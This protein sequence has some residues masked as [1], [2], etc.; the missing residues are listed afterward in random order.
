MSRRSLPSF[1]DIPP[2]SKTIKPGNDFYQYVNENWLDHVHMPSFLSSY[3]VSEEIESKINVN[4]LNILKDAQEE[5]NNKPN[6]ELSISIKLL[7][8]FTQSALH[9]P[10]QK[11]S[12]KFVRSMISSFKCIR[13]VEDVA[14]TLGDFIR[15]RITSLFTVFT[16]PM[17][18]ESTTLR[19]CLTPGSLGLPDTSYYL[20]NSPQQMRTLTAYTK[21]LKK[22][23]EEFDIPRLEIL[24]SL[25]TIAAKQLKISKLDDEI[26]TT[27]ADLSNKYKFIPWECL[28]KNAFAWSP[29]EWKTAKILVISSHWIKSM[30]NWFKTF[31]LDQWKIWLSGSFLLYILPAL[32]PPFDDWHF[33]FFHKRLRDQ[34]EKTPQHRLTLKL[35][36]Q[37]LSAPLGEEFVKNYM[38]KSTKNDAI[39][40][41]E[42]IR[43]VA[44][45]RILETDWL[46]P[47]TRQLAHDKIK[48]IYFGIAYPESFEKMKNITLLPDNLCWNILSLGEYYLENDLKMAN[49]KLKREEWDDPIFLVNAFY[50]NEGNRLIIPSGILQ[51]PFFHPNASD[52]WNFGGIGVTFGHEL[53]HAFDMD[54][55]N[56]DIEGNKKDWWTPADN[57]SYN[58]RIKR[59]I[60]LYNNTKILNQPINGLLTLSENIADLGGLAIALAALKKRLEKRKVSDE[61]RKK[62]LCSF[63][64]SYAVSWRTKEKKAKIFQ[65]LFMDTH[66]P[67][68]MRVNNIVCQFDDWYECFEVKP[69][70]LLY[71]APEERIRIF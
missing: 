32:P 21:L 39:K 20:Q 34:T 45:E 12:L 33:E 2:T 42:E 68:Q 25:E 7:G 55:R 43:D 36:G 27:G 69:G 51:Y 35:A 58:L 10:S 71:K 70:D 37:W 22:I 49:K 64:I 15:Y 8:T 46:Q 1:P 26:L 41:T 52:G 23:G 65:S 50:Y 5:V 61:E 48:S 66:A 28:A 31:T 3:G 29:E 17:E 62:E 60:S 44:M 14:S 11:K 56:Y 18:S 59:I 9:I 53:T 4:L 54:G 40:L 13:S 19:L 57:R 67:P 16:A 47:K 30:N 63:F 6:K 38:H 24:T